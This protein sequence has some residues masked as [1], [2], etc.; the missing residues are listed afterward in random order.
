MQTV[1]KNGDFRLAYGEGRKVA[2]RLFAVYY[3]RN[4]TENTR[5]GFVA[6]KKTARLAV[7]RNRLRRRLKECIRVNFSGVREGYDIIII[8]RRGL[9]DSDHRELRKNLSYM[10]AKAGLFREGAEK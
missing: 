7:D 5:F 9:M 10:L 6:S 2:C 4:S 1:K 8:A 3:R